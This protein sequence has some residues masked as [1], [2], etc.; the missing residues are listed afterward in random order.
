MKPI[1]RKSQDP[2]MTLLAIMF[3]FLNEE[4]K[5]QKTKPALLSRIKDLMPS[6]DIPKG[7]EKYI[8]ELYLLNYREDGDYSELRK[9]NFIDP[10]RVNQKTTNVNSGSYTTAKLPFEGSNLKG[11]WRDD[12]HGEPMYI[13][14]SYGWY[15]IFLFKNDKW[16]VNRESYSN[17][18]AKQI[19]NAYPET[20][21]IIKKVSPG[22]MDLLIRGKMGEDILNFKI[23][24]FKTDIPS[25]ISKTIK[26]YKTY[27]NTG[28]YSIK[29]K[30][31][32][33]TIDGT[34]PI[35]DVDIYNVVKSNS[36][37]DLE[38]TG[39]YLLG[40]FEGVTPEKIENQLTEKLYHVFDKYGFEGDNEITFRFNHLKK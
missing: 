40:D 34:K 24:N 17:S 30:I 37:H 35:V 22:E 36:I 26:S 11:L 39:N 4:K 12:I 38:T 28:F 2:P 1:I 7:Y 9:N 19:S 33:I 27:I 3:R 8:L 25:L 14:Y 5:K 18:T 20:E 16:Y 15:P 13:V 31:R 21:D 6:L 23:K 10:R 29:Y 32:S